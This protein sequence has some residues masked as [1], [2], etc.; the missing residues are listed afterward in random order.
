MVKQQ[1][2]I[3]TIFRLLSDVATKLNGLQ[4]DYLVYGSLAYL[5]HANVKSVRINDIDIIV[6]END[7]DKINRIIT[8]ESLPYKIFVTPHAI[9]AN[10]LELKGNDK[11]PFDIS[12]DSFERYFSK[13]DVDFNNHT[14][15]SIIGVPVKIITKDDLIKIYEVGVQGSND[16][17]IPEYQSKLNHLQ[18]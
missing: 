14:D 13:Y 10:H 12:F 7:F 4:I 9:H 18:N 15:H 2:S 3:E 6:S 11:K 16:A 5:I 17:K 8:K 1:P